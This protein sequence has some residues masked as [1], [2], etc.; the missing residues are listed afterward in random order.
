MK[1]FGSIDTLRAPL[2]A[3]LARWRLAALAVTAGALLAGCG[4]GSVQTAANPVTP[5]T[6][7]GQSYTGPAP[8]SGDVQAFVVNFW[9]NV[10]GTD[11]CGAC[12]IQGNQSP[13]FARN[14]DVNLAYQAA[15]TIVD[16][17]N[18]I[19]RAHV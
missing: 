12:H 3:L 15:Q 11:R 7:N 14:D 1:A 13:M 17:S 9:N 5:P 8:A 2:S 6:S 4:A 10:K 19:G 18:Q 16:L